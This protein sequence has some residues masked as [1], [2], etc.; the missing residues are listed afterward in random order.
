MDWHEAQ[1]VKYVARAVFYTLDR[2]CWMVDWT[3][4]GCG[5]I[6]HTIYLGYDEATD[7]FRWEIPNRV[8]YPLWCWAMDRGW[9]E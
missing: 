5:L 9:S 3:P 6:S 4:L 1:V 8:L 7:E 2:L